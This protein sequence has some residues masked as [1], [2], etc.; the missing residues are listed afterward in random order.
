MLHFPLSALKS[1]V[2]FDFSVEQGKKALIAESGSKNQSKLKEHL[3]FTN[4]AALDVSM[5]PLMFK[6]E[7]IT[8]AFEGS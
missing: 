1:P 7:E 8:D 5:G 2:I 6:N 3:A 4:N